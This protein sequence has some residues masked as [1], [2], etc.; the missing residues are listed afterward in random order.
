MLRVSAGAKEGENG[1]EGADGDR[2][3]SLVLQTCEH[4][5]ELRPFITHCAW[6][7]KMQRRARAQAVS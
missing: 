7:D 3:P 6:V 4:V 2:T 1:V 5:H